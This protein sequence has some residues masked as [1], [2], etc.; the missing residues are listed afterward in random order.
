MTA[1]VD[2]TC[3][4]SRHQHG[5]RHAYESCGCRCL[6]CRAAHAQM[7]NGYRHGRRSQGVYIPSAGTR[8]RLQAL[9]AIGISARTIAQ[10]TGVTTHMVRKYRS[11]VCDTIRPERAALFADAYNALSDHRG[12]G[13]DARRCEALARRFGWLPPIAYDDDTIDDPDPAVDAAA[14]AALR[15][16]AP[17][18][19]RDE[20]DEIA[21][22]QACNGRRV[23]LAR[24][25]RLAAV[26]TLTERGYSEKQ[27]SELL[28][29]PARTVARDKAA[30]RGQD[31]A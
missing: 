14:R 30:I 3:P 4:K 8:R 27:I 18:W 29:Y 26:A 7:I 1:K 2:C 21:V 13:P 16:D 25:E 10:H 23:H 12:T 11:A 24:A 9:A 19:D 31:A 6:P 22:E 5:T 17:T 28:G 20:L 15:L